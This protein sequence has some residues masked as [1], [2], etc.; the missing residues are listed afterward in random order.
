MAEYL[1]SYSIIYERIMPLHFYLYNQLKLL[2]I[3]KNKRVMR[4]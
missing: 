3:D 1:K 4:G 2:L